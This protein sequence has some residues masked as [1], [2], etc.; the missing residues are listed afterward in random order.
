MTRTKHIR[1]AIVAAIGTAALSGLAHGQWTDDAVNNQ[2]I[3]D[4]SGEQTQAK[5]ATTP[6]GGAYISW[7]DNSWAYSHRVV[8]LIWHSAAQDGLDGRGSK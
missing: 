2:V 4:R 6:D 7:F 8:D 1:A 5:I 3:V